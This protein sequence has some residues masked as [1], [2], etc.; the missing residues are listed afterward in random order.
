MVKHMRRNGFTLIELLVVV[1][2]IAL[3]I[4]I[5]LPSL[6]GARNQARTSVCGANLR[7]VGIGVFIYESEFK[8]IP[9]SYVYKNGYNPDGSQKTEAR[10]GYIHWSALIY[11]SNPNNAASDSS[12][13]VGK[14]PLKAFMC[15]SLEK[16]GLPPTNPRKQ[17]LMDGVAPEEPDV[18][19]EQAP[20]LAYTLNEAL[21]P[22]NKFQRIDWSSPREYRTVRSSEIENSAST[23][24]ATEYGPNPKTISEESKISADKLVIKSH[25]PVHGFRP[26]SPA[27]ASSMHMAQTGKPG[28]PNI[29]RYKPTDPEFANLKK[30]P[31]S[32][33]SECLLNVIGRNHG[34]GGWTSR[35]SNFLYAD[36]HVEAKTVAETIKTNGF[37]WGKKF[38]SLSSDVYDGQ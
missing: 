8:C 30:D 7:S 35:K 9:P 27:T 13:V 22:R 10:E 6:A 29:F 1:A 32:Q 24:L 37:E 19:D 34:T 25:R 17:D 31:D 2:I 36:G 18:V 11:G 3:L 33:Q 20:R 26:G 5:L 4:A 14:I 21:S 16:G 38:Y 28:N 12:K 15:P 23:I